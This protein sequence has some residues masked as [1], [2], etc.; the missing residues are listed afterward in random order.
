VTPVTPIL[1]AAVAFA[2]AAAL[3]A[4]AARFAGPFLGGRVGGREANRA[5]RPPRLGGV[6]VLAATVA[7][8]LASGAPLPAAWSGL[9]PWALAVYALGFLDDLV[10]LPRSSSASCSP[11]RCP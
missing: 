10:D 4:A 7:V 9:W 6:V 3:S 11:R 1:L 2:V 5:P 8:V